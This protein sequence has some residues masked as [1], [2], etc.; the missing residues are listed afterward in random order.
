MSSIGRA[1]LCFFNRT[2]RDPR[3]RNLLRASAHK[4]MTSTVNSFI[5]TKIFVLVFVASLHE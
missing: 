2:V 4:K 1:V 5:Q 3:A